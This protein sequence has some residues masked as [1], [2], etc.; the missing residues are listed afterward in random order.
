LPPKLHKS[1]A[2]NPQQ[3]PTPHKPLSTVGLSFQQHMGHTLNHLQDKVPENRKWCS[4]RPIPVR[5]FPHCKYEIKLVQHSVTRR[6]A[7]TM[8]KPSTRPGRQSMS[9]ANAGIHSARLDN[10]CHLMSERSTLIM[11]ADR[12]VDNPEGSAGKVVP[13]AYGPHHVRNATQSNE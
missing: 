10:P 2:C 11:P 9:I 12:P 1:C 4:H 7:P 6:F 13:G 5:L 3:P 8:S